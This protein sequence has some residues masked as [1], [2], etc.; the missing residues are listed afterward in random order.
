MQVTKPDDYSYTFVGE[1]RLQVAGERRL[2]KE[3][4][5]WLPKTSRASGAA[6]TRE[7]ILGKVSSN[8]YVQKN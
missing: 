6:S 1:L 4:R 8:P 3:F 2:Q 7:S 5:Q